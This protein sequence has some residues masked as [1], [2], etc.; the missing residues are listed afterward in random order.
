M[1]RARVVPRFVDANSL[2]ERDQ[3]LARIESALIGAREGRGSFVVLEGPAGIGKTALLAAARTAAA[4]SGMRVLRSRGSELERD[5]A[6]GVVRQLFEPVLAGLSEPE[7]ADLLQ[8]SSGS[9]TGLRS[10]L[11]DPALDGESRSD[12][13][14][15]FALLHGLYWLCSNLAAAEPLLVVVDDAH[16]AD[17]PSLRYLAF[18][19]TRLEELNVALVMATRPREE[20]TDAELLATLTIDP[21]AD[22]VRLPPLTRAAVAQVVDDR[23]Q[24]VA[25]PAFVTA[26]MLATRGV[27]F[28]VR[29]LVDALA[30]G[31]IA[32]TAEAAR[33]V[34]RIGGRSVGRS[35]HLRL[36]RL[37]EPAGRFARALAVLEEGGLHEAS[38]LAELD[39]ADGANAAE[40]LITAGILE[41]G[42]PLAFVHP[43]VRSGIYSDLTSSERRHD[44]GRAARI[45]AERTGTAERVAKHLLAS[46]PAADAWV[47]D[48]LREAARAAVCHG[49]PESASVFLRRVLEE[50]PAPAHR[51]PLLLELGVAEAT[52]GIDGWAE[53]MQ[54]AVDTAPDPVAA[55]RAA[56]VLARALNR[57]QRYEEAVE[58][59]DRAAAVL[60]GRDPALAMELE[61]GAVIAG[62]NDPA[63]APSMSSRRAA[64]REC[65]ARDCDASAELLGVASFVSVLSNEPADVGV[66]LATRALQAEG[67]SMPPSQRRAST[68]T[69]ACLQSALRAV[70]GL[71]CG[72]ATSPRP[73]AT[74]AR[75]LPP[76]SFRRRRCTGHS[77]AACSSRRS[78]TRAGSRRRSRFS[79][80]SIATRTAASSLP[81]FCVSPAARSESHRAHSPKASRISSEWATPSRAEWSRR[82][83]SCPGDQRPLSPTAR[84]ATRT[85]PSDCPRK[86][87]SLPMRSVRR[88]RS[89]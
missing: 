24:A 58:V 38:Q 62:L 76:P 17:V 41:A 8:Q 69:P 21:S 35:I 83:R 45:L 29:A 18:L 26:C 52:A 40:L 37:P 67:C 22:V 80:R 60:D 20:G 4:N 78:S 15:S 32:P 11:R 49:A 30:E 10:L 12:V 74:R 59:L 73:R 6:F 81:R 7:R 54:D 68:A 39:D 47:V 43:I 28:L 63:T 56:R 25:D 87:S 5:F 61:A 42:H 71:L 84:S 3:E 66:E 53:H 19:L 51:S 2:L 46:E 72:E 16:W 55:A 14:A 44:H 27:P 88:V 64:L 77:M 86:S 31:R 75:P 85:L 50:P 70:A 79:R 89:V 48:R 34:E 65:A 13:D 9:G 1:L 36:R 33:H 57:G 23:L 82:R